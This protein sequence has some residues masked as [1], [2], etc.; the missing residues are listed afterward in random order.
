[1]LF[2]M[3]QPAVREYLKQAEFGIER[4]S[5]RVCSDGSLSRTPHPF[6]E[7]KNI[8]RDFCENQIELISDV[9]QSPE[10]VNAQLVSLQK[11]VNRTLR[12]QDE[13]LWPFSNPP[14]VSAEAEIPIA[15]Y[16]GSMKSKSVYRE[17][18]AKKYG[19][20]KM[21]LSGIHL[22][23]SFTEALLREGFEQSGEK[24][25][26]DYK[27]RIYLE[28][29]AR[30][31]KYG[32]LVVYLTAASPV[33]DNSAGADSNSYSSVRCSE[34]GYW[35]YF[36]PVFDYTDLQSYVRSIQRYIDNGH[37]RSVSELY[38]PVRLKPKGANSLQE[39]AQKG[40]NHIELRVTDVN[41]LSETGIFNEDI[42]FVHILML[43]L[44][45]LSQQTYSSSDQMKAVSDV[46]DAAVFG[47]EAIRTRAVE[48][49]AEIRDF[50]GQYFPEWTDTVD[51]QLSKTEK[52]CSYA[53]I[54]SARFA[55]D[56][57]KKGMELA[58]AYRERI[59]YV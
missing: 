33:A 49:L 38:Y 3:Q 12:E 15:Q 50:V 51:Y 7:H 4:E 28:L 8:D 17:Y 13:Y 59:G 14:R 40:I 10:E 53:E 36:T 11:T 39:L 32:W 24:S 46:K 23:F 18:L 47:S 20:R 43:Y 44:A 45:S 42:R 48:A 57:M 2:N 25:F 26:D 21:L 35:N 22:N 55:D 41:P 5:L 16:S 58:K 1:M 9:F 27:N 31:A 37:L 34:L 56:Y 19:K 6:A 52:G 29:G 54:V 30:L